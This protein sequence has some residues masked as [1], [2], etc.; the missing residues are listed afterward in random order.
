MGWRMLQRK[1]TKR[2]L[3]QNFSSLS[4]KKERNKTRPSPKIQANM[5]AE[6]SGS[7]SSKWWSTM[8]RWNERF[9]T[10]G[11]NSDRQR[12]QVFVSAQLHLRAATAASLWLTESC[13]RGWKMGAIKC[14]QSLQCE[15]GTLLSS[16]RIRCDFLTSLSELSKPPC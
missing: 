6:Y 7:S 14:V 11:S 12:G 10:D 1:G 8:W 16:Q 13:L 15:A 4:K 5:K 2:R 3:Y 9:R